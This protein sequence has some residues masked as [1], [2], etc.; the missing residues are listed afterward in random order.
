MKNLILTFIVI[1]HVFLIE[2]GSF[3]SMLNKNT[4]RNAAISL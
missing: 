4:S 1:C 3:Y 2:E